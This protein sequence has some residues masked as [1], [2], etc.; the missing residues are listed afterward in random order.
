VAVVA[1]VVSVTEASKGGNSASSSEGR[2]VGGTTR[3]GPVAVVGEGVY[4]GGGSFEGTVKAFIPGRSGRLVAGD[5]F[6][7]GF[8]LELLLRSAALIKGLREPPRSAGPRD[9]G[10]VL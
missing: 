5:G 3:V 8:R 2:M 6:E 9:V 4:A 7:K 10:V 1:G